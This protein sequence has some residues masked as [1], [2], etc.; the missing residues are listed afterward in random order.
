[1]A[2]AVKPQ[3]AFFEALGL[4]GFAA[5]LEVCAPA[6]RRGFLVIAAVK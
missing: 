1:M 3:T 5:R 4:P 2:G 6:R